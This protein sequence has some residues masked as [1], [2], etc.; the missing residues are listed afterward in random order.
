MQRFNGI[1]DIRGT[2]PIVAALTMGRKAP[3]GQRGVVERDR[4]H[5]A[6][7]QTTN[8][9]RPL[10]PA[11]ASF[12]QAPPEYR[13]EVW[14]HLAHAT[15]ADIFEHYLL[16][17][18]PPG[19]RR[20]PD[21]I[22]FCKG[23]GVRAMRWG[24]DPQRP[25]DFQE[26]ACP[27]RDCEFRQPGNASCKPKMQFLFRLHWPERGPWAT[28]PRELVKFESSA[29][30]TVSAFVGLFEHIDQSALQFAH[31]FATMP[32]LFGMPIKL[33]MSEETRASSRSKYYVVTPTLAIDS[34]E[35]FTRQYHTNHALGHDPRTRAPRCRRA[36]RAPQPHRTAPP[37]PR[38][39][40]TSSEPRAGHDARRT[41][42]RP[43]PHPAHTHPPRAPPHALP[44]PS[45]QEGRGPLAMM[46]RQSVTETLH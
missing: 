46:I 4:F 39:T 32:S 18:I 27:N 25:R 33:T 13:R 24:G 20:H 5:L 21:R 43:S 40:T 6:M 8:N 30:G 31:R 3:S 29:W 23:D 41:T 35:W 1:K 10:H 9:E 34:I 11:F 28:M 15:H 44:H 14:G 19:M 38:P 42:V 2:I 36:P 16:N 37:P 45:A 7:P 26:I 12:N 17:Y 22:P